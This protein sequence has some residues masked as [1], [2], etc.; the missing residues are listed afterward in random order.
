[1]QEKIVHTQDIYQGRV[2]NLKVHEVVL[3][4][5]QMSKRELIHHQG[6]VALVPIDEAGR[7]ILVRQFRI[8]AGRVLH[9]LPA[10][11]LEPGEAPEVCAIRE[12]QEETGY[13]P[14]RLD[15]LGGFFVAPGYT[16]EYIH[17]FLATGLVAAPLTGDHDEFLEAQPVAF[18]Q[19]LKLI[20]TGDIVD[21]KTIIGL[22]RAAGRL[23]AR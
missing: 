4:D 6:A 15:S 13:K 11:L 10:G 12:L 7:V 3:P 23:A 22:L 1:M 17:L 16:S 18:A 2:V 5:G 20:E 9:E 21:G 14:A 19:A 8:G